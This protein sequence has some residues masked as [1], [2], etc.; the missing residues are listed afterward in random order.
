MKKII[1]TFVAIT[2]LFTFTACSVIF[3]PFVIPVK[4]S[5]KTVKNDNNTTQ[6]KVSVKKGS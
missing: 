1:L 2:T 4:K 3:I 6:E 5:E